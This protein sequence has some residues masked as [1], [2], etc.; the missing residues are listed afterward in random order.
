MWKRMTG[1]R[2]PNGVTDTTVR[3]GAG[4]GAAQK[5]RPA[6]ALR[7][8]TEAEFDAFKSFMYED[9]AQAIARGMSV[10]VEETRERARQQL[11]ELLADGLASSGHF[12][13]KIVAQSPDAAEGPAVGD[14]WVHVEPER[15]RAFIYFI[16]ID[17]A[18]RGK[19]YARSAML[20]LE[21]ELRPK[22]V[23]S[24]GLNVFGDNTTARHLY[25]SLGYQPTAINMRKEI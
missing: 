20:A 12:L 17:E 25:E 19:G 4:A 21:D 24:I 18:Q 16:G 13:W 2:R 5:Q 9:Y 3:N 1:N 8:M 14:L 6:V 15:P 11:D 10:P 23:G 7:P 22:G